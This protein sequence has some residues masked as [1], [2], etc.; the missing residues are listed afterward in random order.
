MARIKII[1]KTLLIMFILLAII[2][3]GALAFNTNNVAYAGNATETLID[4]DFNS[5]QLKNWYAKSDVEAGLEFTT[6]EK[7]AL[8]ITKPERGDSLTS[9]VAVT[10]D[11]IRMQLDIKLIDFGDNA[12]LNGSGWFGLIYNLKDYND[13]TAFNA[14]QNKQSESGDGVYFVYSIR[15]HKLLFT[16]INNSANAFLD[17]NGQDM[18]SQDSWNGTPLNFFDASLITD[19]PN[20]PGSTTITNKTITVDFKD[21]G[22]CIYVKTIGEEG[23][24]TLVAKT[25]SGSMEE[26][27]PDTPYTAFVA[28]KYDGQVIS[29]L[30]ITEFKISDISGETVFNSFSKDNIKNYKT[31]KYS[32]TQFLYFGDDAVMRLKNKFPTSTP[33]YIDK[34]VTVNEYDDVHSYVTL[35]TEFRIKELAEGVEFGIVM[36]I[37]KTTIG[38]VGQANTT[39]ISATKVDGDIYL[40]IKSYFE[41]DKPT[42]ILEPTKI[43]NAIGGELKVFIEITNKGKIT[44]VVNEEEIYAST[45]DKEVF[46]N[47]YFGYARM[48]SDKTSEFSIELLTAKMVCLSYR[49]PENSEIFETFDDNGYNKDEWV[50]MSSPFLNVYTNSAYVNEGVLQFENCAQNSAFVTQKQYSDFE[51]QYDLLNVRREVVGDAKGNKNYPISAFVGIYW[52]VPYANLKLGEGVSSVYPLVYIAPEVDQDTWDRKKDANGNNE[53]VYIYAMGFGMSKRVELPDHYDFWDKANEGKVL[54]FKLKVVENQ[55]TVSVKYTTET[56]WYVAL[57]TQT[58]ESIVGNVGLTTMGCN[59]YVEP[60]SVGAT[61]GWFTADNIKVTNLDINPNTITIDRNSSYVDLP[62]DFEYQDKNDDE[63]Y[64]IKDGQSTIVGSGCGATINPSFIAVLCLG[65]CLA[66]ILIK[67]IRRMG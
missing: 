52:G 47:K 51:F 15:A 6:T 4:D 64:L 10:T 8:T 38:R 34:E 28:T 45:E 50:L 31:F 44:L 12:Y 59:Y 67:R 18:P 16:T 39:Y 63:D 3:F 41:A 22:M 19:A 65:A 32:L 42:I 62:T 29:S 37:Q 9:K 46:A 61:C 24:G 48:G 43:S 35:D 30:S 11:N 26:I 14:E 13:G 36:G 17:A 66:I 53:P 25:K 1:R 54:Q 57:T 2:C 49:R 56:E 5:Q 33:L 20:G 58:R 40:G 21:R 60:H 55:V 7:P 27:N 23:L